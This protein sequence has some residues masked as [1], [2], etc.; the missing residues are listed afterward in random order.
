MGKKKFYLRPATSKNRYH[1][2]YAVFLFASD[3]SIEF[4][5]DY[6]PA[7]ADFLGLDFTCGDILE[8]SR[9][10]NLEI[11]T[12]LLRVKN[13]AITP[14][15]RP[16]IITVEPTVRCFAAILSPAGMLQITFFSHES[17]LENRNEIRGTESFLHY[18]HLNRNLYKH[19]DYFLPCLDRRPCFCDL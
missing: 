11:K 8:I 14:G 7:A 19:G 18:R 15:V 4:V 16:S 12:G 5:F 17:D 2:D 10:G 6:P 1:P 13:Y 3:K 9:A